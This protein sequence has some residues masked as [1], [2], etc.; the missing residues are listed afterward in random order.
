MTSDTVSTRPT[1][2]QKFVKGDTRINRRGRPKMGETLAEKFR[3]ALTESVSGDYTRLD[4]LIDVALDQ[5]SK[6][7]LFALEYV[8]SRGFGKVPD[9]I[10]ITPKPNY[11]LSKLSQEELDL[12]TNLCRKINNI[13]MDIDNNDEPTVLHDELA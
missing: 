4:K 9:R 2:K 5:A 8:L 7:K 10:E 13:S 6:G 1:G 3:N 12:F 11:D